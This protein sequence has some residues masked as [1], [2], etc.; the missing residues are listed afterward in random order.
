M[1]DLSIT[2][3]TVNIEQSFYCILKQLDYL[4]NCFDFKEESSKSASYNFIEKFRYLL[5]DVYMKTR[6]IEGLLS[7]QSVRDVPQNY[8]PIPGDSIK[9]VK[10]EDFIK[11]TL[12]QDIEE[13]FKIGCENFAKLFAEYIN[14]FKGQQVMISYAFHYEKALE[15][16][17]GDS[18]KDLVWSQNDDE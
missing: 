6:S 18:L 14:T 4:L 7:T 11:N 10:N 9:L 8:I 12:D 16:H 2:Q 17:I 3:Q 1:T 15:T 5:A 13:I